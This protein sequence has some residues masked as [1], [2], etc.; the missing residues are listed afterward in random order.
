MFENLDN[1]SPNMSF[2]FISF[3]VEKTYRKEAQNTRPEKTNP[4]DEGKTTGTGKT[5]G[6]DEQKK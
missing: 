4:K 1:P 6:I 5:N 3:F 2:K